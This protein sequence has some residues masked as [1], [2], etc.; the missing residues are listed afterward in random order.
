MANRKHSERKLTVLSSKSSFGYVEAFKAL[1]TNMTY[2]LE[3][4]G[5]G[6]VLMITSSIPGEGKSN[7]SVNL[8]IT[9]AQDNKK[10]ILIDCDMRKGTLHRYLNV[11]PTAAGLSSVLTGESSLAETVYKLSL[12]FTFIPVGVLPQNPSEL[13]GSRKMSRL[14]SELSKQYDYVICDTAPVNAVADTSILCR[15]VDGVIFVVSHNEVTR[16]TVLAAKEQL[17][18]SNANILGVVLNKYDAKA[19]GSD[20]SN[21]YSYYNYSSYGYGEEKK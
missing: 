21:Y 19:T 20:A 6:H 1:R 10:V 13:I 7:I 18:A 4:T 9:L 2:L 15:Y 8:A 17:E 11:P 5:S 3:D 14:L 12:G 16:S